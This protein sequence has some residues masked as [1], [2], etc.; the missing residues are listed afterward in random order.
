MD[1]AEVLKQVMKI[2]LFPSKEVCEMQFENDGF[3]FDSLM[4]YIA[5]TLVEEGNLKGD[6]KLA[7]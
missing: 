4:G 3:L 5:K 2:I 7:S 1:D 6:T